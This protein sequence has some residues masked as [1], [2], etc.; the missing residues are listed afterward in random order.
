MVELR[1]RLADA[2]RALD[3]A[4]RRADALAA[5]LEDARAHPG[6][7]FGMRAEKVLR[8]AEHDAAQRRRAAEQD[9]ARLLEG[10]RA[11]AERIVGKAHA[12]AARQRAVA[13]TAATMHAHVGEVRGYVREELARLHA[14]LGAELG[15]FDGRTRDPRLIALPEQRG[16]DD[17]RRGDD[18]RRSG[19][20]GD[21]V[22]G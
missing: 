11:E 4:H 18:D 20:V 14:L 9:A 3:E 6:E 2:E 22:R 17:D 1:S 16:D 19:R 13:D 10:A 15:R 8:M 21:T 12:E 5:A 7:T